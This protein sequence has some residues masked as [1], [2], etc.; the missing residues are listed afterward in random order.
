MSV[1]LGPDV[2][3][4]KEKAIRLDEIRRFAQEQIQVTSLRQV[5]R[6]VGMSPTGLMG[7]LEGAVPYSKTRIRLEKWYRRMTTSG[8]PT[9]IEA[10]AAL[11]VLTQGLSPAKR[12]HV[13]DALVGALT[14]SHGGNR[15]DWVTEML[16][17][18]R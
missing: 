2:D 12:N 17:Y 18:W 4:P 11:R 16:S 14:Y 5:S 13:A 15:P 7:F 8:A 9:A 3:E 6:D 1:T 10:A